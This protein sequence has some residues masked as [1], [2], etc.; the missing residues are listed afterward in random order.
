MFPEP[1]QLWIH[2][3]VRV[4]KS[5]SSVNGIKN[6]LT[7]KTIMVFNKKRFSFEADE[8]LYMK[9]QA[10]TG[11][12]FISPS[13]VQKIIGSIIEKTYENSKGKALR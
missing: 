3:P 5:V 4:I 11:K 1:D 9:L 12:S 13:D 7:V 6:G 2:Q 10:L 8:V